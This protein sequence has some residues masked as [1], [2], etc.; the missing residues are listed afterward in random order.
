MNTAVRDASTFPEST[1][2]FSRATRL[3]V[4]YF[5]WLC[6]SIDCFSTSRL[7][8]RH[9]FDGDRPQTPSPAKRARSWAPDL[10]GSLFV[11]W[12][13]HWRRY[14]GA[15]TGPSLHSSKAHNA[16]H[17]LCSPPLLRHC[18]NRRTQFRVRILLAP[19]LRPP[20]E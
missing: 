18:P 8:A 3:S 19:L 6:A 14:A 5:F 7:V 15:R 17:A 13:I 20:V 1:A 2:R 11:R 9:A 10:R 4:Q 16:P 12:T